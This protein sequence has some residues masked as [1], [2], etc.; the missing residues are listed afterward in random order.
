MSK[1]NILYSLEKNLYLEGAPILMEAGALVSN[2]ENGKVH[3][4]LKFKNLSNTTISMVKVGFVLMDSVGREIGRSEKQ[5]IDLKAK[6]NESFGDKDP[7]Y[8]TDNTARKFLAIIEEV[9]FIDGS[10]WTV[11][12][13][14][15]WENIPSAQVLSQ[16]LT[17]QEARE[18]FKLVYCK[19]AKFVAFAHK[20]LW[21]CS[22]GN[23]NKNAHEKC[24]SCGTTSGTNAL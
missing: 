17:T 4:Q 11:P 8:L 13:D 16:K 7:A 23:V 15:V 19:Q 10:I 5:Y 2:T 12:E 6:L 9:C 20:D 24:C 14:A 18:E 3:I 22:C 1:Y 21:V